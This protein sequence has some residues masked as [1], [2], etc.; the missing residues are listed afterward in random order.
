MS[1]KKKSSGNGFIAIGLIVGCLGIGFAVWATF[2]QSLKVETVVDDSKLFI[3]IPVESG[4]MPVE[5]TIVA[6][7]ANGVQTKT[8]NSDELEPLDGES[9]KAVFLDYAAKPVIDPGK[10]TVGYWLADPNNTITVTTTAKEVI[11]SAEVAIDDSGIWFVDVASK[12][13]DKPTVQHANYFKEVY[14][15]GNR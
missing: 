8:Y 10:L 6:K 5:L 11:T 12:P 4:G 1:R 15:G 3:G 14:K 13:G 2:G 7:S 9:K